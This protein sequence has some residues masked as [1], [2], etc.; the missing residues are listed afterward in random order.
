MLLSARGCAA[1]E[2]GI[3]KLEATLLFSIAEWSL[4]KGSRRPPG[5]LPLWLA[6]CLAGCLAA[7]LAAWLAGWM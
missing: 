6:S 5:W 7:W 4:L 1:K 3:T 2:L